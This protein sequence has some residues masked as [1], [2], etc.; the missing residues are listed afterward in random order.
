M[1]GVYEPLAQP[2]QVDVGVSCVWGQPSSSTRACCST[3]DWDPLAFYQP[4]PPSASD[5]ALVCEGV[6]ARFWC[7]YV[8]T[9]E[10]SGEHVG[11]RDDAASGSFDM[12][13]PCAFPPGYFDQSSSTK[14]RCLLLCMGQWMQPSHPGG[15]ALRLE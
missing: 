9:Q 15:V 11:S 3:G 10:G 12:T 4:P 5:D 14:V 8:S 13:V 7:T 1:R 6:Y 2:V